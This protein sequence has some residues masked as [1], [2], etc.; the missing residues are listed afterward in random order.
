MKRMMD[1]E[2]Q[3]EGGS[4]RRRKAISEWR[5]VGF[6]VQRSCL[7]YWRLHCSRIC[8]LP[9]CLILVSTHSSSSANRNSS[10]RTKLSASKRTSDRVQS[11]AYASENTPAPPSYNN[12]ISIISYA[13]QVA[14]CVDLIPT[15]VEDRCVDLLLDSM[16]P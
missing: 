2:E 15:K 13:F 14:W 16:L 7:Y 11:V 3:L 8:C 10:P 9:C 5:N 6:S 1:D 12:L 4:T